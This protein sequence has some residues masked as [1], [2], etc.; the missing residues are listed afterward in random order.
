M[1]GSVSSLRN[2]TLLGAK[3]YLNKTL[4]LVPLSASRAY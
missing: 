2:K 1:K 4:Q 3:R